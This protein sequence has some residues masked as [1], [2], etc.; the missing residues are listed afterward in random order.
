MQQR[1]THN[2]QQLTTSYPIVTL[3]IDFEKTE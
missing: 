1:I 3:K 2:L